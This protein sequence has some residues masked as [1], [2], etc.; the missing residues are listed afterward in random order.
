MAFRTLSL[1]AGV[2]IIQ[3]L[4][5]NQ[6]QAATSNLIRF[7]GG[8]IQKLGG[9]QSYTTTL[10][11]GT[12][13][14]LHGWADIIGNAYLA[15]GTEQRLHLLTGGSLVDI[16]PLMATTNPAVS[17]STTN[18]S[19]NVTIRDAAYNPLA[20]DWLNLQTQVMI[21]GLTLVGFYQVQS[22]TSG[23]D[24]VIQAAT[25]ATSTVPTA[26]A[27][28]SFTTSAGSAIVTVLMA[29]HGLV[30]GSVVTFNLSTT[31]SGTI[32]SGTYSVLGIVDANR[33]T[34][35]AA[36]AAIGAVTASQ[37]A[38]NARIQYLI[39]TGLVVNTALFGYGA[40][41]Y[42]SGDYGIGS[43]G[44][45]AIQP[46]RQWSLD[47]W[48]Q[49][50]VASP[51]DGGIYYWVPAVVQPCT[52]MPNAPLYN[53]SIFVMP[54]TQIILSLG[55]EI[56]GTLQPLLARWCDAGDF[57]AWTATATNQAGSYTI[58]SGTRL[59]GG[60]AVGLGAVIWTDSDLWSVTY[61][62]FPL[63]FG[64]NHV[65]VADGL[66]SQRAAA[67][68]ANKVMW[69]G[70]YQ[71]YRYTVGGGVELMECPVWDFY[72]NNV[73]LLQLGQIFAAPNSLFNEMAWHFPL[74]T[75]SPLYSPLNPMGYLKFNLVEG[76]WDYGLSSQYQRTAWI[77]HSAAGDPTGADLGGLLQQHEHGNDANGTPMQWSWSTG[78]FDLHEG[79]DYVFSDFLIPDFV[80]T[81]N[82]IFT[83]TIQTT[84]YPNQPPTTVTAQMI[85]TG[86]TYFI[87]Y[88]A[89]GRQMSVGFAGGDVG[90][91]SRLGRIRIRYEPDGQN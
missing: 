84:D 78:Y 44:A 25:A 39:H 88:A 1:K 74:A 66:V 45:Q 57:T 87:T 15:A 49:Y 83:P 58:P 33:F 30:V 17:F 40:G 5:L 89:R 42:G 10:M 36:P 18:L 9:W 63:V 22:V 51:S 29:A 38:G 26:G 6:F 11:V 48:G 7:Y 62:G 71:F 50:L 67:T 70:L 43:T 85:A 52:V 19:R 82:P 60:L 41:D 47:H 79:E 64:F 69:L 34:I 61:L 21:G 68:I 86:A 75:T 73:D 81:G 16:T 72:W 8:L 3:S 32:I 56:G 65:S 37:N 2:N 55:A 4:T 13:R 46:L 14:G 80:T 28:P 59:V 35:T 91:F 53:R 54:Q 23:T 20:S 31:V 77:D 76:V 90:T 12:C 24:Y 27:V